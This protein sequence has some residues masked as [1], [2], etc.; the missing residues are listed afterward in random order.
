MPIYEYRCKKCGELFE[1]LRPVGD[2]GKRL[3]CPKC[4]ARGVEKQ[5][6]AFA[7]TGTCGKCS[8]SFT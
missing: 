3:S 6:S 2:S 4:G 5:Y 8:S 1:A 7:V